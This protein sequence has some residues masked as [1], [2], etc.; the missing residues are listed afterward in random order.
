[1]K[2]GDHL[3]WGC[4]T[5]LAAF[6]AATLGMPLK[7]TCEETVPAKPETLTLEQAIRTAV[8]N[9]RLLKNAKLQVDNA[10][11]AVSV[12]RIKGLP[13]LSI[14]AAG[15]QLLQPVNF[16]FPE[17]VFGSFPSIGP[18]PP[19]NTTLTSPANFSVIA[20]AALLQPLTQLTRVRLGVKMQRAAADISF[21]EWR[22]QRN[23][24]V[25]NVKQLYYGLAQLRSAR[26]TVGES[27]V[28]LTELERFV[29]DNVKQGTTLEADLLDV[30]ARLAK[31]K[32]E[33]AT[34]NSS[35]ESTREE[36][37]VTLGR[38][39]ST[40]FA[41]TT[42]QDAAAPEQTLAEL[43]AEAL[44]SRPEIRQAVLKTQIA[45]DDEKSK[46]SESIP[47]VSIGVTYTL[48]QNIDV[49]PRE[50]FTA[51]VIATWQDP[52]DWGRRRME[53]SEKART[54]E[55]AENGL[56]EARSQVLV[57]LNARYR[58]LQD[59]ISLID[60]DRLD[61]KAKQEKRRVSMNRYKESA[62]L[63][64]DVL[65]AD[66]ALADS[67]RQCLQDQLAASTASA[68]LDQAIGEE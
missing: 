31:E 40:D 18:V 27:I 33:L 36:L 21:E 1:M 24:L 30:Q 44:K 61:I 56:E 68:K 66:T 65:E 46:R 45:A 48:Q 53:R 28:F 60:A 67:N 4:L 23:A 62:G 5:I 58:E 54:S 19:A 49:V 39:V 55:Q 3:N 34:L 14:T 57:D 2:S 51:G 38:D 41:I 29:S 32:H 37:N 12:T 25:S 16:I 10:R 42:V 64:K 11:T 35:Y 52:F 50:L 15:S 26:D 13:G 6:V 9:N 8:S 7:A 22:S 17:G 20:N 47:D 63:L 43:Q 59:A